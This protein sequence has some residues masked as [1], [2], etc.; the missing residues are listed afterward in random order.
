[1]SVRA[2][3]TPFWRSPDLTGRPEIGR[4]ILD[5]VPEAAYRKL[6]RSG[7]LRRR[8]QRAVDELKDCR[9]CPRDCRVDR[10]HALP[11]EGE[12]RRPLEALRVAGKA[13]RRVVPGH[14]PKGAACFTGRQAR[15][16]SAFPHFGE[17]DC[18]R[19]HRGSGTIF[20]SFCN[21]RCVFCQNWDI[22]QAG[23][24]V[25][26]RPEE[27]AGLMLELQA[28]GCHNINFVTPEHVVP[29]VLEAVLLAA[30]GGLHLPLVY[31]TS[32]YD[33]ASS[34]ELLDGVVDVYMPD[35]KYWDSDLARRYLKAADY[36]EVARR[37]ISEMHR[38]V[39][40]LRFDRNGVAVRGVLVRHLVMP[41]CVEDSRQILN[42]LARKVSVDTFVNIMDQ[43]RPAGSV[44]EGKHEEICRRPTNEELQAVVEAARTAGL[45]R[46]DHRWR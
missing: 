13:P 38:Q 14:I 30:E 16:S 31:N 21:L 8:V 46:L 1:M 11:P 5:E 45:W 19:G 32:A 12:Q 43:Y 34:L 23:E 9:V 40:P 35:F 17:E 3:A 22:S 6:L 15:I 29:Q 42:F 25:E 39:G 20:F 24:G 37:V 7:E 26:V 36:P 4:F 44:P 18:L 28:D 2:H 27:L 33:S 41:G 10:L